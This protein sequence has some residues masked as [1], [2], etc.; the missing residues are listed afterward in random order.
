MATYERHAYEMA[1]LPQYS[2][3]KPDGI[4]QVAVYLFYRTV[5]ASKQS[6]RFCT[7]YCGKDKGGTVG[8][9][10]Y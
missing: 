8:R 6:F 3:A 5:K 7:K 1:L 2:P 10:S 9:F 4:I